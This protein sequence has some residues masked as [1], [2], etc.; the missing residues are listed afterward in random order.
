V[1]EYNPK[2]K[3]SKKVWNVPGTKPSKAVKTKIHLTG[4]CEDCGVRNATDTIVKHV[5]GL[6]ED[7]VANGKCGNCKKK[8]TLKG[9]IG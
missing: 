6:K 3:Q 9:K 4:T 5:P 1:K 8:I 2:N 7:V